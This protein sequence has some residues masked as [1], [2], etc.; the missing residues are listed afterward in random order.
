MRRIWM[1]SG[2][3]AALSIITSTWLGAGPSAAVEKSPLP[4]GSFLLENVD[5]KECVTELIGDRGR[6]ASVLTGNDCAPGQAAQQFTAKRLSDNHYI[7]Q[8][9]KTADT[10]A[11]DV[12]MGYKDVK[13]GTM[14]CV[15]WR[16]V[17]PNL[18]RYD[19]DDCESAVHFT[20][21][22]VEGAAA[23]VVR[24]GESDAEGEIFMHKDS[25]TAGIG[26]S[27]VAPGIDWKVIPA[28]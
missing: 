11:K 3:I 1:D 14:Q 18:A 2:V 15:T 22:A 12:D 24:I 6:M 25:D 13:A 7:L 20:V 9:V 28:S 16:D 4:A 17:G 19:L 27:D 23:G 5:T 21:N 8:H 10:T 26:R